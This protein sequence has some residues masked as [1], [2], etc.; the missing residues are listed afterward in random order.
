MEINEELPLIK[1]TSHMLK[2]SYD[3]RWYSYITY[4]PIAYII[5]VFSGF[6]W[7]VLLGAIITAIFNLI[8]F[9]ILF[10]KAAFNSH[11]FYNCPNCNYEMIFWIFG[12]ETKLAD[13]K[14][15]IRCPKCAGYHIVDYRYDGNMKILK[16]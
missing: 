16:D 7:A 12:K 13:S 14:T 5:Y 9:K 1:V 15:Q 4:F 10:G 3:S 8:L 11:Y 2:Q 6:L